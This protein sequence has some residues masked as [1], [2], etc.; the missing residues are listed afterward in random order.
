[1]TGIRVLVV[2]REPFALTSV[3]NALAFRSLEV[4]GRATNARE[5]VDLQ[6]DVE[7]DV[8]VLD[9]DLGSGPTGIDL[10]HAL[11]IRQP[12][13]G[14]VMLSSFRD[15]RLFAPNMAVLPPGTCYLCKSDVEDFSEV[16]ERVIDVSRAPLA[17]RYPTPNT[18]QAL[19]INQLAVLQLVADGKS[20]QA[21]AA[22]L[23]MSPKAV[24]QSIAKLS[25]ILGVSKGRSINQRVRLARAF[26]TLTGRLDDDMALNPVANATAPDNGGSRNRSGRST[27][28]KV[29][30]GAA[31]VAL[32]LGFGAFIVR[33][34]GGSDISKL[35]GVETTCTPVLM[36]V[37]HGEDQ[38]NPAGGADILS[39][40]GK[41]HAALYS[42]LFKDY[43]ATTHGVGPGG[44]KVTVC[45][46]GRIIAIDPVSNSQNS[47]PGTNP[48]KTIEPLA[49]ALGLPIE[50]KDASGV[51]YSTVYDWTAARRKTLL[52]SGKSTVIGWDKQGLNPSAGD[53]SGKTI[54]EK[55]LGDYGF[56]PLLQA[57]PTNPNAIVGSGAY[58]TPNRTDLYVFS[59]QDANTGQF[60]YAERYQQKFSDDGGTTWYTPPGSL[61]ESSN[62]NAIGS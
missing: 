17:A 40:A 19:N 5:A 29:V 50:T 22:Q 3:V 24:E 59:L 51:S 13:I 61:P 21:I 27:L 33:S 15:P 4:V 34:N 9:L 14:I 41:R 32:V 30:A 10:A 36:V 16:A 55:S 37:R 45:P 38:E 39:P 6:R 28:L 62:A 53:L 56:T 49:Q 54:N 18:V 20:T 26:L 31:G 8:A 46:I 47:G 35:A 48:Y 52:T 7:P 60:G 25:E 23:Q 11:R 44:A 58:F 12:E 43:V 2:Q 57:M 1:M 42:M